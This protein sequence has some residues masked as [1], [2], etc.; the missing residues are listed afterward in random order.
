[1]ICSLK[2]PIARKLL[3]KQQ[4]AL[5]ALEICDNVLYSGAFGAGKTLLAANILI[6][7]MLRYPKCEW[8]AGSQTYKMLKNSM[9]PKFFNELQIYQDAFN[10]HHIPIEI[11]KDYSKGDM[12]A[13]FYNNSFVL[14]YNCQDPSV[15]KSIDFD[16]AVM[17]EPVDI[18][19][20]FYLMLIGRLRLKHM[21]NHQ[22]LLLTGN[23]GGY[24]SWVYQTFFK[25]D[26][27]SDYRVIQ[28]TSFDNTF[29]PKSYLDHMIHEFDEDYASRFLYGKWGGFGGA[30]FKEFKP[31]TMIGDYQHK[32]FNYYLAGYDDGFENP[33]CLLIGGVTSDGHLYIIKELYEQHMTND[34]FAEET[35]KL[36][37]SYPFYYLECDPSGLN[38]IETFKRYG[39]PARGGNNTQKNID[40][41]TS[42]LKSM[43]HQN[44]FYVD[45]SCTNVINEL[46]IYRYAKDNK[47]GEY[48]DKVIKREDHSID[49]ARYLMTSLSPIPIMDDQATVFGHWRKN[50]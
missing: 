46:Q 19:K 35:K 47:T 18:S 33:A 48:T 39:L 45:R 49:A 40:G 6:L 7:Y 11:L 9:L 38:A 14:F 37:E 44:M 43:M 10:Q 30:V 16:G 42:K 24:D 34:I 26:F 31:E 21:N 32:T 2:L 22:K 28:T 8:F 4:Q 1:V 25:K 36:Y 12:K 17:D 5:E 41:G 29:L 15:I 13:T 27:D 23:P 20:D 3:P 50:I